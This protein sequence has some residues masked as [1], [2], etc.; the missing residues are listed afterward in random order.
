MKSKRIAYSLNGEGY[1]HY[2][3]SIGII[4]YLANHFSDFQIDVYCYYNAYDIISKELSLPANVSIK[5]NIGM[6]M[7]YNKRGTISFLKT[8]FLSKSNYVNF[9]KIFQVMFCG[10]VL[11][12]IIMFFNKKSSFGYNYTK[13][14]IDDFDF[15][16]VDYEPLLPLVAKIRKKKFVTVD[17]INLLLCGNFSGYGMNGKDWFYRQINKFLT[18]IEAPMSNPAIITTIYDYPLKNKFKDRII[19]VGPLIR[20]EIS[21]LASNVVID[22]FILVYI[23]SSIRKKML[24]VLK[25]FKNI[26][27]VVFTEPLSEGE[28]KHYSDEPHI[29][30]HEI[31]P[32]IFPDYLRRCRAIISAAGYTS[33]SEAMVLKKPLFAVSIGGVLAF[34]QRLNLNALRHS[35]CGDGCT[36]RKFNKKRLQSFLEHLNQYQQTLEERNYQDD[37][38]HVAELIIDMIE[39]ELKN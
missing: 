7:C 12:P 37:T 8:I 21:E 29:E 38:T 24:P 28:K 14:Y 32:I 4:K 39:K 30:F 23:K 13:K 25:E 18:Q 16:I 1:G 20:K 2:G 9:F 19:K 3:R 10:K 35:G 6:H 15:A 33:F 17:N 5:K 22:D 11:N 26:R 27:F 36:H 31:D 34:E